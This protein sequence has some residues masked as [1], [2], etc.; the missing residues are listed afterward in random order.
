M[1]Q[2]NKYV[3]PAAEI[4]YAQVEKGVYNSGDP[5]LP[6]SPLE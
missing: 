5:D 1:K 3:A 2:E 4:L 6:G